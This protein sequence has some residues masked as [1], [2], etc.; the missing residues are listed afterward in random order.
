MNVAQIFFLNVHPSV[1]GEDEAIFDNRSISD[2]IGVV[3]R[4]A[5]RL[6]DNP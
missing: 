6:F 2:Q 3:F 1:T 4:P 5:T